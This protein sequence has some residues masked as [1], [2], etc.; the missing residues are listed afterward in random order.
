[1]RCIMVSFVFFMLFSCYKESPR[2]FFY[3][4]S[5]D[6][7]IALLALT[8]DDNYFYGQYE[9]RYKD[10]SLESGEVRGSRIGDTLKGRFKYITY[11]G[12][13]KIAFR[14][15]HFCN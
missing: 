14:T 11:G 2:K 15:F 9:V 4:A 13:E 8:L 12:H 7:N 3:K 10:S 6:G 5:K 1:M